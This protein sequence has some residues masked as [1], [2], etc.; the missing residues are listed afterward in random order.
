MSLSDGLKAHEQ[1]NYMK[2]NEKG[3]K[4][5]HHKHEAHTNRIHKMSKEYK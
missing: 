1:Q 2:W 4:E 3:I 5:S